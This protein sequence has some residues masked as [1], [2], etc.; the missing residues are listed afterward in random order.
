MRSRLGAVAPRLREELSSLVEAPNSIGQSVSGGSRTR[1]WP[2]RRRGL[3]R[4]FG[5][6]KHDGRLQPQQRDAQ[7]AR[8]DG[9]FDE[10]PL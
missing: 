7:E 5:R 9:R 3:G 1:E 8:T 4:Y 6:R 10:R 2:V